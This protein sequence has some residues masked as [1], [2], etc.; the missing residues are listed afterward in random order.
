M[1]GTHIC[2]RRVEPGRIW[3]LL[4]SEGVTHYNGAPTVQIGMVNHPAARRLDRPVTVTVAGRRP[5]RRSSASS[6][7]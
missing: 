5:R 6:A 4:A 2:L 7:S 3:E 1:A